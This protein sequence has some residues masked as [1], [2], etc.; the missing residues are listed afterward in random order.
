MA[1]SW[2]VVQ[3]ENGMLAEQSI[4]CL[5]FP[6]FYPKI[7]I[8]QTFRPYISGYIF[9]QFDKAEDVWE[10]IQW[11]R[12]VR[13]VPGWPAKV[14]SGQLDHLMKL[15]DASGYIDPDAADRRI[16]EIGQSVMLP[17]GARGTV[18]DIQLKRLSVMIEM[19]GRPMLVDVEKKLV[20]AIV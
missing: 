8:E 20:N 16:F 5:G 11:A 17:L 6:T 15:T 14:R 9:V 7:K 13:S 18:R 1:T 10:P 12:G 19:F 3:T 4:Y 2:H